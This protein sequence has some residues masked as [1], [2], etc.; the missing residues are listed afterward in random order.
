MMKDQTKRIHWQFLCSTQNHTTFF[1]ER[2]L[3]ERENGES[4]SSKRMLFF[5]I[6]QERDLKAGILEKKGSNVID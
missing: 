4:S 6:G 2:E 3:R 1:N 5:R